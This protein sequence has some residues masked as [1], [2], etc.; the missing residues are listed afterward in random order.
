MKTALITGASGGI[1]LELARLFARDQ[2]NLILVARRGDKL[3]ELKKELITRH[4]IQVHLICKDLAKVD[5]AADVFN[6]IAQQKLAVNCLVNNAGF[7]DYGF[8]TKS[9]WQKTA[10]MIQ[11]NIVTLTQLTRLFLPQLLAQKEGWILNVASTASFLPGPLMSVYYATKAYVLS[12]SEALANEL[13]GSGVRVSILCPGPT[14]SGFQDAAQMPASR[15]NKMKVMA[16][17]EPVARYGYRA[18]F[19]GKLIA[20]PGF[21]NKMIPLLVRILPR[22]MITAMIRKISPE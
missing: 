2:Y 3:E 1:G 11:L 15:L 21:L 16:P 10:Q 12:F 8:F 22:K 9:N 6:V 5:A 4:D 17:P 13:Q 7:G 20:I 19:K 14:T 18:L